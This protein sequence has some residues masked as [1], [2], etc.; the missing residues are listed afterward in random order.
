MKIWCLFSVDNN[1]D[2]PNN[3]LVAWWQ[4]KPTLECL[5]DTLEIKMGAN[6]DHTVAVV[7]VWTGEF[8]QVGYGG[9]SYRLEEVN[10]GAKLD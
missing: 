7:K 10:E 4:K 5:F 2:Q 3:N 9:T 1:Y 6:D 8:E